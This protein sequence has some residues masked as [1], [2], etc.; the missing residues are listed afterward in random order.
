MAENETVKSK[1]A[2]KKEAKERAYNYEK[3][4]HGCSQCMMLTL[5]ELFELRDE[6]T[7]KAASSLCGGLALTGNTC[8]ALS[9]AVMFLSM[10]YGRANV[11]EGLAGLLK[12]MLPAYRLVRWFENEFGSAVCREISGLTMDEETL[13]VLIANPEAAEAG[14]DHELMEKC[15]QLVGKTAEKVAE[16]VWEEG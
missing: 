1:D 12:G 4:Y 9:G 3:R 11:E 5:Q 6:L 10:K 2:L 15:S 14:M 7:L 16:I 13:K 8:G